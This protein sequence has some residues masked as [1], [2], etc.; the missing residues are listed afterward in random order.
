MAVLYRNYRPKNFA[1]VIGQE[2]IKTTLQKAVSVG[3]FAHAYLFTGTRGTG[4]TSVARILARAINCPEQKNG[5]PCNECDICKQFLGN[6]SLDLIEIDAASNTGIE[7]I[8]EIIEHLKFSPTQ[9]QYKVFIIDE[10]HMLSKGA[11]NALLKTLEEP[12]KHA[13]FIL[14]TTEIH[15]VPA[16][17]ISRTQRFDFKK[18]DHD[19]LFVHLK[20]ISKKEKIIIDDASL[21]LILNSAEGSVRDALSILDKLSTFDKIDLTQ[22]EKLLGLTNILAIQQFLDLLVAKDSAKSLNFLQVQFAGGIDPIQFNKDL[23]E[24]LRKVLLVSMGGNLNSVFDSN[25]MENLNRHAKTIKPHQLLFVIRLFLRA[26]KDFQISPNSELPVEIAAA[27]ACLV[28]STDKIVEKV[29]YVPVIQ[30]VK[31]P[32]IEEAP[33]EDI[34]GQRIVSYQELLLAWPELMQKLRVVASTMLAVM[35]NAQVKS[36]ENNA[37][38]IAFGYKFHKDS[39]DSPRGRAAFLGVLEEHFHSKF[40]LRTILEKIE[41]AENSDTSSIAMEVFG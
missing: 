23:L 29:A 3:S 28:P 2:H 22:A 17:I 5:E 34:S 18:I 6:K 27:E 20:E 36:I 10:V 1:E 15:K 9:A 37:I 14:A 35:K 24:Y 4:K 7:N 41:P 38:V 39:L 13:V 12:P 33:P 16:T 8:R 21:E 31:S 32:V 11:F 19:Q 30:T 40:S 25:Q 26:N